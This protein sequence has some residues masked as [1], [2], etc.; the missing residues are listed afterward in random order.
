MRIDCYEAFLVDSEGSRIEEIAI[1]SDYYAIATPNQEYKVRIRLHRDMDDRFPCGMIRIGLFVDGIDVNYWKRIDS[2]NE[3]I[4]II[5]LSFNGYS[6][7]GDGF[8]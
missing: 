8:R 2:R 4:E 3:E 7:G 6:L 1:Q 5:E